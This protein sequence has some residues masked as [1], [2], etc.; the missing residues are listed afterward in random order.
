LEFRRVLFRSM[1]SNSDIVRH[2]HHPILVWTH[3]NYLAT[4]RP[5]LHRRVFFA[6]GLDYLQL[7]WHRRRLALPIRSL[8]RPT[9]HGGTRPTACRLALPQPHPLTTCRPTGRP[10][11][12]E[13]HSMT[14]QRKAA[15][16]HDERNT[17]P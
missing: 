13:V 7:S 12:G 14:G 6:L 9:T 1:P 8:S 3:P 2:H 17:E 4:G 5:L 10:A 16:P 11:R 15:C